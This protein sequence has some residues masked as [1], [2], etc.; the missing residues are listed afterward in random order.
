MQLVT[1]DPHTLE[2]AA[3]LSVF[4]W[5]LRVDLSSKRRCR[6][7]SWKR[8]HGIV[9]MICGFPRFADQQSRSDGTLVSPRKMTIAINAISSGRA[10]NQWTCSVSCACWKVRSWMLWS[11][12]RVMKHRKLWRRLEILFLALAVG[13]PSAAYALIGVKGRRV[14]TCSS[15][16]TVPSFAVS[17][18]SVP[19]RALFFGWGAVSSSA[20]WT[21]SNCEQWKSQMI[22]QMHA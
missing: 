19:K 11:M 12:S 3:N 9:P 22:S 15:R 16:H 1:N 7:M 14:P 18:R 4:A 13:S 5:S 21:N 10:M 2:I 20:V 6:M 17:V 8:F